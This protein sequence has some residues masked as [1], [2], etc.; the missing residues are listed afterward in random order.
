MVLGV[1]RAMAQ[2]SPRITLG[3]LEAMFAN[4]RAK[5][6]WNVDGP[7]L[8]GYFFLHSAREP[9]AKLAANLESEGFATVSIQ[10][11][12]QRPLW[13]LHVEKVEAHSP[14]TLHERNARFEALA[15]QFA[16]AAYDGMDVGP[17]PGG[18]R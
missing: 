12:P 17:P 8:W 9:L 10:Q 13:R 14:T 5:T 1:T 15:R 6:R 16:V 4:M 3:Q 11:V 2:A 7:L 18:A